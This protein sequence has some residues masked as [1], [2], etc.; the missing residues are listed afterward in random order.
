MKFCESAKQEVDSWPKNEAHM[1]LLSGQL[2]QNKESSD[3]GGQ[4][5]IQM[6]L[7]YEVVTLPQSGAF[8]HIPTRHLNSF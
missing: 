4:Q 8:L 3:M 6:G 5:G 1:C 2:D 7:K